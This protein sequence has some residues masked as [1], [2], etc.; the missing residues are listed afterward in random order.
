MGTRS[1]DQTKPKTQNKFAR[2]IFT[3][4]R[5]LG[6][7]KEFYI[8][9]ILIC[10][11][12]VNMGDDAVPMPRSF[13]VNSAARSSSEERE[14]DLR[15]LIR[16]ASTKS[17]DEFIALV[18]AA[19]AKSVGSR[20]EMELLIQEY[21]KK[22]ATLEKSKTVVPRSCSAGMGRIDEENPSDFVEDKVN[23]K[24]DFLYPRSRTVGNKPLA[25]V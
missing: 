13:S 5:I 10:S 17:G 19:S 1:K 14:A 23:P 12:T 4:F 16:A 8:N 18:K 2:I 22:T 7:A 9:R 21:A 6:K 24:K 20:K 11:E 3:P 25:A 15:E